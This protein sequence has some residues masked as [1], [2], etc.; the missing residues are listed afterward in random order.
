MITYPY[1]RDGRFFL[2][3][4]P[5]VIENETSP[6]HIAETLV[7]ITEKLDIPFVFKA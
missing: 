6:L 3:A 2:L 5:C 4:G 1:H 7:R